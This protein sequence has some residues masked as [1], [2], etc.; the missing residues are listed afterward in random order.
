MFD[1]QCYGELAIKEKFEG[2]LANVFTRDNVHNIL[3][4][5]KGY[6]Y[7]MKNDFEKCF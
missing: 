2:S 6:D 3:R 4:R 1:L 5:G 7:F